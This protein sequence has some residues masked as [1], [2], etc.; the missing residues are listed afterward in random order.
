MRNFYPIS[1]GLS[2]ILCISLISMVQD[3]F[4][5]ASHKIK[6]RI[7]GQE[8]LYLPKVKAFA[9]LSLGYKNML[10]DT[11]W[12]S[13]I[14]YFGKHHHSDRNYRWLA[15]RCEL[16]LELNPRFFEA[17]KFCALMLAWEQNDPSSA[18]T[19]LNKA[20]ES[21]PENWEFYYYRGFFY[22]YFLKEEFKARDD[23]VHASKL[24]GVPVAVVSL[25]A[26][27]TLNINDP[28]NA[29]DILLEVLSTNNDPIVREVINGKLNEYGNEILQ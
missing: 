17:Y 14:N 7:E 24:P 16:V 11:F 3:L 21:Y 25:A 19:I 5:S 12:F 10:S 28:Q 20:I 15:H 4:L 27:Q 1:V 18:I 23:L 6:S 9:P 29:R 22:L 26:R 2:V 13:T 8:V